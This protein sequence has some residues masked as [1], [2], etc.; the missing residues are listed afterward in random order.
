[1]SVCVIKLKT[2]CIFQP[3]LATD[4]TT[5]FHLHE[6][7]TLTMTNIKTEFFTF[8]TF[9]GLTI[10]DIYLSSVNGTKFGQSILRKII[11]IVA[12]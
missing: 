10:C 12:T 8:L 2:R 6:N 9:H 11:K 5:F 4:F 7:F 1:M 3:I